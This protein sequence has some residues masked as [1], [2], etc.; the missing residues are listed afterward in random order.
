MGGILKRMDSQPI[1]IGGCP[2]HVHLLC[3]LSKKHAL[4][5]VVEEVKSHSSKWAKTKG[6]AYR[7]FYWQNDYGCFSV[8]P[9]EIDVVVNYILNQKEH[10]KTRSFQDEYRAFLRKYEVEFDERYVWD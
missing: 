1:K 5:K 3:M 7:H 6:E 10:H 8:N 9:S 2:D 4:M